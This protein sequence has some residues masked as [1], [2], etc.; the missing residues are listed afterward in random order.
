MACHG[1]G[2]C[3]QA[4][5]EPRRDH[6]ARLPGG[7]KTPQQPAGGVEE[8]APQWCGTQ[9]TV[10]DR[11]T[12]SG[13]QRPAVGVGARS[14]H[15]ARQPT[16][17]P[18][19]PSMHLSPCTRSACDRGP[20]GETSGRPPRHASGGCHPAVAVRL[21]SAAVPCWLVRRCRRGQRSL[22]N[23]TYVRP[24]HRPPRVVRGE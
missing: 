20:P 18:P 6:R 9:P 11:S 16:S 7:R 3:A 24:G 5:T 22:G 17:V 14:H 23:R 2:A 15:M 10:K 19:G 12:N 13:A 8:V 1:E 21:A 4:L